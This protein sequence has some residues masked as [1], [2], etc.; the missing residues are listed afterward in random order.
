MLGIAIP[1]AENPTGLSHMHHAQFHIGAALAWLGRHDA[2]VDW[3]TRAADEGYPSYPRY[4]TDPSLAPLKDH[5]G[6][7]RLL[8]RLRKDWD[9]WQK[10]LVM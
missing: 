9:R 7:E 1:V 8:A 10:T 2:A 6:F 4:A 3:L 5:A